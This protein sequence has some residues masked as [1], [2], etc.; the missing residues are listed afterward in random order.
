VR[1]S[2]CELKRVCVITREKKREREK[3]SE[4]EREREK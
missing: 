3:G 4:R 1:V 2:A